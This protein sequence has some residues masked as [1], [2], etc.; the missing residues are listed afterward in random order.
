MSRSG[1]DANTRQEYRLP[2]I[3]EK[4]LP[5]AVIVRRAVG[6][7]FSML[8]LIAA[9]A[10][11][12]ASVV[13]MDVTISGNGVLEPIGIWPVRT[14]EA[15]LISRV[16]VSTGDTVG[17]GE[18]VVQL[19]SLPLQTTLLQLQAQY[20]A[21]RLEH[22]RAIFAEPIEQRR[23]EELTNQAHANLVRARATLRQKLVDFG[24][25]GDVDSVVRAYTVG[26]HVGVDLA[27]A[28]V[29]SAEADVR[30]AVAQH[31]LLA[32]SELD[33]EEQRVRLRQLKRQISNVCLRLN[34][35]SVSAP[36]AGMVLTERLEQLPGRYFRK[37]EQVLEVAALGRWRAILSLP[38][39]DVHR[40]EV[41]AVVKVEVAAF[42]G[43]REELFGGTVVSVASDPMRAEDGP[44][45]NAEAGLYRV[46]AELD[47]DEVLAIGAG[48]LRR[49][50]SVQGKVITRS[51]KIIRLLVAYIHD[52]LKGYP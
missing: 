27:L 41:G 9:S 12:V 3:G 5:G 25:G 10:A 26:E 19:D 36:A 14:Q 49:G 18:V 42:A 15:G 30:S 39:R 38:E 24:F 52:K 17:K 23:Q 47:E 46:I 51:G 48:K 2:E 13:E 29:I 35:L 34:R 45:A 22:Q 32:N 16:L 20:E 44:T 21:L 43:L 37:G 33:R 40:V 6:A 1:N 28:D 31:E 8:A 11:L 50:F 4:G 7:I